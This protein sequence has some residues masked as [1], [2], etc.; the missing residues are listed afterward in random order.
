MDIVNNVSVLYLVPLTANDV[1]ISTCELIVPT[2]IAGLVMI[3]LFSILNL[4]V[5]DGTIN[6]FMSYVN[7]IGINTSVLFPEKVKL[8]LLFH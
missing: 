3:L 5:T 8:I 1:Q 7:I 6:A 4:T 2:A